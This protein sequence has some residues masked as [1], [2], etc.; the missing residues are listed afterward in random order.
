M[1]EKKLKGLFGG[2]EADDARSRA[3]AP[4][5][6]KPSR[7]GRRGGGGRQ[8]RRRSP[9]EIARAQDFITRYTTGHP[10]EGFSSDEAIGYLR[11]LR[12]EAPPDVWQHATTET[13]RNLPEDQRKAFS[14]MLERRQAG[15]GLVTVERTGE[16]RAA[17]GREGAPAGG[18]GLDDVLGGLFG[19]LLGGGAAQSQPQPRTRDVPDRNPLDDLF[20][21]L[22][23]GGD[24][25]PEPRQPPQPPEQRGG[26]D[27]IL[28][29]PL[30]KAVL[31][32]LAAFAMKE[33][34]DKDGRL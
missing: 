8:R 21:G 24:T 22:F 7:G 6:A 33:M 28:S 25:V 10:S 4:S 11:E 13:V 1:T 14:E 12:D 32:G 26:V 34:M 16:A 5:T 27:E 20:G 2:G 9:E 15:T 18:L 17:Q 31:G 23:G 19:G 3:T 30:G 29:S